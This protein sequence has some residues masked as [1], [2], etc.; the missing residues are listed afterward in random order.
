MQIIRRLT[1]FSLLLGVAFAPLMVMAQN[2]SDFPP[3]QQP[4]SSAKKVD[5]SQNPV[6]FQADN[7]SHDETGQIITATGSVVMK[8]SGRTVNADKVVYNLKEDRVI[9]T[10][11]VVFE[12]ING[13]KHYADKVEFEDSLKNGF[14]TGLKTFLIDGSKFKAKS[15]T[16]KDGMVTVMTD[17]SYTPCETC[18]DEEPLWQIKA[19]DVTHNKNTQSI[20]Y[21]NARFEMK[22]VPVLY[23]PYFSHPDGSVKRKSGFLAPSGGYKSDLGAFVENNYYWSIA[24]D[25]DA[26]IGLIAMTQ[27]AP[28]LVGEW[29]QR[30]SDAS[31]KASASITHSTRNDER[32]GERIVR[33]EEVRGNL[34]ADGLWD[35]NNEWRSG[36]KLDLASDRQYLRQYDFDDDKD[37]LQSEAYAERFAGR[38]Y[39]SARVIG[40]QDTRVEE[41][42]DDQPNV[43]PEIQANFMGEPG[44]V[45]LIGGRWS[46]EASMLGLL[47]S[48][49]DQDMARMGTGLGW[50]RRLVS[51]YG[52]V[53]VLDA[54]ARG[55]IYGVNDRTDSLLDEDDSSTES[56]AFG[57][58]NAL[59]SYP[60]S[61][62][63][64]N[65]QIVVEP[66]V[67]LTVS[68]NMDLDDDIP[69]ED[70]EDV[71]VDAM[72][73]FEPNRF[74]GLDRVEDQSHATYGLKVGG[75]ADDGSYGDV[76]L[77][78]SYRL[79][80]DDNPFTAGSGLDEQQS[81]FVGQ[82]GGA[83][84]GDYGLQ[85][86]FQLDNDTLAS[87]RHEIDASMQISKLNL[88]TRYLFAKGLEGTEVDQTREQ[89]QNSIS[90]QVDD[91]W[92]LRGSARHELAED[93]GLREASLGVDY[94]GQ[95]FSWSVTGERNL[96]SDV[97]G[98]SETEIMFR[99]GLKNLGEFETS[100]ISVL[101]RNDENE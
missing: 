35:I 34:R 75:Y 19:S 101:D 23:T 12:D 56:R 8:Q 42:R 13:D 52:L 62:R 55:E 77:G 76:F 49:A 59:T 27:E 92:V 100:G 96:T 32:D 84:K 65:A 25:K 1:V 64:T 81:D 4:E 66:L 21:H 85:Y 29:R 15:G 9:A 78:Q 72:N 48:N 79:S 41:D 31:L 26:T 82:I 58:M 47:R 61:K 50:S 14:V 91:N 71:Q 89:V 33:D 94:L 20:S 57:Y 11:N 93:E 22:G 37:V 86:R 53:T 97:S 45:P 73:L 80:D 43:L 40:F 70:S 54:N 24:P 68:P 67:S 16:H 28:V 3:Q 38:D 18:S 30:W 6:D 10:G 44:S 69:N 5:T 87:Q 36:I 51:D 90:Y 63:V 46:A 60:V 99:I 98:D 2:A 83:Y 95:C 88:S 74:P 7:L 17:A 39:F